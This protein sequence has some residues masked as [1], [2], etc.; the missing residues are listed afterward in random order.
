[1]KKRKLS[2]SSWVGEKATEDYP[3]HIT[4]KSHFSLT[5]HLSGRYIKNLL[6]TKEYKRK[7]L[8]VIKQ[9]TRQRNKN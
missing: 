5:V 8:V 1:M 7:I 9:E 6:K 4:K 2:T 3:R